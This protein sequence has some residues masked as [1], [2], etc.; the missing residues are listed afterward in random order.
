[1]VAV[2]IQD[3]K[4]TEPT[5]NLKKPIL[6][7]IIYAQKVFQKS[8]SFWPDISSTVKACTVFIWIII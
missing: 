8:T 4:A 6:R 5:P 1:M 3:T 2:W 7:A